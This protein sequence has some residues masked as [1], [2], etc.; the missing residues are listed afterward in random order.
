MA[1]PFRDEQP[2]RGTTWGTWSLLLACTLVFAFAQP[3]AMQGLTHGLTVASD[4]SAELEIQSF[5]DRWALVPCEVTHN[6][7]I[8]DGAACNGYPVDQPGAYA[9]KNVW[10]PFVTALFLHANVL[11]LF[12][13]LLF[14]WVFGRGLEERI[15]SVGVIGLFLAGGIAA[16]LGYIALAP[17]SSAP[18]LGASGAVAAIMGAYLVLQPRR[19]LLS[20]VYAA[21]I[22]VVYLP[23]WALLAFF[24]VSQFFTTAGTR[25]AWQAHVAGMVFGM[26]VAALWWWR[27]PALAGTGPEPD[28]GARAGSSVTGGDGSSHGDLSVT[29][30]DVLPDRPPMAVP[31]TIEVSGL[32]GAAP[33]GVPPVPPDRGEPAHR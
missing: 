27:E 24:F 13:N 2:T 11:H 4:A 3:K 20:F 26:A 32:P 9:D 5:Q 33:A 12:G 14:L 6:Q 30:S 22:Q 7:S 19:R 31:A 23:A 17:E 10:L 8:T 16:F 15:G 21:G 29:W 28:D 18:V 1:Y 25:V